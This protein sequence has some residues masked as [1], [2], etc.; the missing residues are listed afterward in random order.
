MMSRRN[1]P[2]IEKYN[3]YFELCRN[4]RLLKKNRVR[5]ALREIKEGCL[6]QAEEEDLKRIILKRQQELREA[7]LLEA[8]PSEEDLP[9][10]GTHVSDTVDPAGGVP[11]L[12]STAP[13]R[14]MLITGSPGFG[15]TVLQVLIILG[16]MGKFPILIVD[17]RDDYTFLAR[18]FPDRSL[19]LNAHELPMN[20]LVGERGVPFEDNTRSM[21]SATA[22]AQML[23][24]RG[25]NLLMDVV[26]K[27]HEVGDTPSIRR[28]LRYLEKHK[29]DYLYDRSAYDSLLD[30]LRSMDSIYGEAW[31]VRK[32]LQISDLCKYDLVIIRTQG[33]GLVTERIHF[34]ALLLMRAFLYCRATGVRNNEPQMM[35]IFEEAG[36]LLDLRREKSLYT[37]STVAE[38][39]HQARACGLLLSFIT[40]DPTAINLS[41]L[42]DSGFVAVFALREG[43]AQRVMVESLGL[44]REAAEHLGSLK[45]R[46]CF[47]RLN[48]GEFRGAFLMKVRDVEGLDET[49]L[50]AEELNQHWQAHKAELTFP[51]LDP[52]QNPVSTQGAEH[53]EDSPPA[54]KAIPDPYWELSHKFRRFLDAVEGVGHTGLTALYAHALLAPMTG[55]KYLQQGIDEGLVGT[56]DLALLGRRGVRTVAYLTKAGRDLIHAATPAGIGGDEHVAWQR[57]LAFALD[58]N[59]LEVIIEKSID[60]K[61]VDIAHRYEERGGVVRYNAIEIE[62]STDGLENAQ[63]D[64]R[65]FHEIWLTTRLDECGPIRASVEKEFP[66]E[67]LKRIHVVSLEDLL[68][69]YLA[70]WKETTK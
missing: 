44:P 61:S 60:G 55:K 6:R 34:A 13:P 33:L 42:N 36:Y 49:P 19:V 7:G 23:F 8:P 21:I 27:L 53:H 70:W 35:L 56:F 20:I 62:L 28:V 67:T 2:N 46:E 58:E 4:L 32:G 38:V 39:T 66:P 65:S 9:I 50:S 41:V 29:G 16:S 25:M 47:C 11:V 68:R 26:L 3:Y 69:E 51:P 14:P 1:D 64:L 31:N 43:K 22:D 57:A 5:S 18:L 15:K 48:T 37:I 17:P 54:T 40:Q 59:G 30:R 45:E 52:P 63:R 24:H 10:E 12:V